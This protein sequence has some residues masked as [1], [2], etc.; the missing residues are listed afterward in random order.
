MKHLV[1]DMGGSLFS[2]VPYYLL[3]VKSQPGIFET[4][5]DVVVRKSELLVI[6]N[7]IVGHAWDFFGFVTDVPC[8]DCF[9]ICAV[10]EVWAG[11]SA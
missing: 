1:V 2:F 11:A 7:R 5:A 9:G 6:V 8:L 4:Y 10:Q 3:V